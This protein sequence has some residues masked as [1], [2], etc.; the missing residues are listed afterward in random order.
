MGRVREVDDQEAYPVHDNLGIGN[1]HT[2]TC[3][4]R[5]QVAFPGFEQLGRTGK[6]KRQVLKRCGPHV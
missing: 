3:P 2:A 1:N 4:D 6:G 5:G